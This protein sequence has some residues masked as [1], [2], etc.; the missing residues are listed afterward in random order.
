MIGSRSSKV[1]AVHAFI[2]NVLIQKKRIISIANVLCNLM[3]YASTLIKNTPWNKV[4]YRYIKNKK[5]QKAQPKTS[6]IRIN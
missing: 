2:K 5:L 4:K 6:K 1:P 3:L